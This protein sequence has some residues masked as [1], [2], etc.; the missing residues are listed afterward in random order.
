MDHNL[1]PQ[2]D[3]DEHSATLGHAIPVRTHTFTALYSHR[4]H[5]N[6]DP[7]AACLPAYG[8]LASGTVLTCAAASYLALLSCAAA[9]YHALLS[10]TAAS[11]PAPQ[12]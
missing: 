2:H 9:S 11:Y 12:N 3:E 10:C 5:T 4:A 6:L 7:R 1:E 8:S